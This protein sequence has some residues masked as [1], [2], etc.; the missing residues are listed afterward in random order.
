MKEFFVKLGDNS[1]YKKLMKEPLTYIA[2]AAL[3]AIFQIAHFAI[4]QGAWGVTGSFA[5]WGAW[6][7][8]TF[9]GSVANWSYFADEK[10]QTLL[11]KGFMYDGGSIRNLGII[12]GALAATLY[13]SQFKIK[14]I[15]SK[16]QIVAAILGGLCMGYGARLAGGCNIGALF[17]SIAALSL[18]G[19]V[20]GAFLLVGAFFG[21]KLL[22]KYFM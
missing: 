15:K 3:L 6:V 14:K 4:F 5:N 20:F 16:K 19:W 18:S 22:A 10:T 2:G 9:G 8:E 17:T 7:Y 1:I 21:S 11:A 12:F 13:A